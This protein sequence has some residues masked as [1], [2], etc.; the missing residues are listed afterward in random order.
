M[1]SQSDPSPFQKPSQSY[2]PP[3][4]PSWSASSQKGL[5]VALQ[6]KSPPRSTLPLQLLSMPSQHS[7]HALLLTY[8]LLSS[9]SVSAVS[10]SPSASGRG[11]I[12]VVVIT[13]GSSGSMVVGVVC[14]PRSEQD[15]AQGQGQGCENPADG[16]RRGAAPHQGG[17]E[18]RHH[19]HLRGP[20]RA[21]PGHSTHAALLLRVAGSRPGFRA[22]PGSRSDAPRRAG[23]RPWKHA[24]RSR[25]DSE[26]KG[27]RGPATRGSA[28][29]P[30]QHRF[31]QH[32][33]LGCG[34]ERR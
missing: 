18:D 7:S 33:P 27:I 5:H 25:A 14:A 6:S 8:G 28:L 16:C 11:G 15:A 30:L 13:L 10:P 26:P 19:E 29:G 2:E 23:W 34:E 21:L 4:Q 12:H 24:T 22:A 31:R 9:Q 20:R 3:S 32:R 17:S 1:S